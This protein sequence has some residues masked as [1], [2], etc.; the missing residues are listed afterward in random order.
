LTL[1]ESAG[2]LGRLKGVVGVCVL[3]GALAWAGASSARSNRTPLS[4]ALARSLAVPQVSSASTGAVA[5]DLRT[6]RVLYALNP[7]LPLVPASNEKLTVSYAALVRLGPDF[8]FRT[9]VLGTGRR[10]G[11]TWRGDL[12]LRG[13]G[14]PTLTTYGLR[15]LAVEL[16][17]A[18]IR[19]VTGDVLADESR[20]DT[21]RTAPGWKPSFYMDESPPL[22]ALVVNRAQFRGATSPDP[23][24]A[25]AALFVRVLERNGIRV[26]GR[27]AWGTAPASAPLL[28]TTRSQPLAAILQFMDR[29]SD[30]FTAEMLLKT[31]GHGTT[32]GGAAVVVQT[33]RRA[34][35][36]LR[37]VRIAD[38]SGLSPRDRLTARAIASILEVAWKDSHIRPMLVD[39]LSVAGT[40]GTLAHRLRGR[41]T[42]GWIHAKTGTTDIASALSGY[43]GNRYVFAI[44]QDGHP[45]STWWAHSAQDSFATALAGA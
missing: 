15:S 25:A 13:G 45:I 9:E 31:L 39:A 38:G 36:P 44:V 12:Y 1:S 11:S 8:R 28:A 35:V 7:N 18:G 24:G 43:A 30:N 19:R 29:N 3:V 22:S 14:D 21:R 10:R 33:L 40:N 20:F 23:A 32:A 34:H 37:G 6:G 41:P 17:R 4:R 5:L 16:R 26:R 27:S 42:Q 2:T